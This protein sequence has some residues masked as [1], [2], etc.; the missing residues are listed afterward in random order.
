MPWDEPLLILLFAGIGF[1]TAISAVMVTAW[2]FSGPPVTSARH[3]G[4][5]MIRRYEFRQGYLL[6][7]VDPNDAF[8]TEG[9]DR[10]AAW[11]DLRDSLTALRPDLP[12]AMTALAKRGE[13]FLQTGHLGAD[14]LSVTG[15][16]E[17]DR[18]VIT[19]MPTDDRGSRLPVQ[20]ATLM[21]LQREIVDLRAAVDQTATVMWREGPDMALTWANA[22]YYLLAERI[23]INAAPLGWPLPRVFAD[24]LIPPPAHGALRRCSLTD[25]GATAW[26]DVAAHPQAD[27]TT[28]FA[29]RPVDRLVNAETALRNFVQT[30]SQ[31]FA[32]LPVGLAIFDR[33]RNLVLFNPA[34]VTLSTLE[35]EFLSGR[36][37]LVAFLDQLRERQRMPE[38]KNY[39]TWRDDI[40]RLEQ[41]AEDGTYHELWTLPTGQSYRVIGRPHH[42]GA[43]A[44]MFEDVSSEVSLTRQFRAD[45]DLYQA[46]L[47]DTDDALAVFSGDGR[48]VMSNDGY[49]TLWGTDPRETLGAVSVVE[50]TRQWQAACIPDGVFGD[51][52]SFANRT[53]GRTAWAGALT[54]TSGMRIVARVAP[55]RGGA[56]AVRFRPVEMDIPAQLPALRAPETLRTD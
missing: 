20:R 15:A 45:L 30:L 8:L 21:A 28:L 34:L 54:L 33:S 23:H 31:T 7:D 10:A 39:K 50:A 18:V 19:V 56:M 3:G 49:S 1:L 46:V 17:A 40:A 13:A 47:N 5:D 52:R 41:G 37:S 32:H 25:G 51:I 22:P 4:L 43:V 48:L 42:D 12:D 14:A 29:A 6:N 16:V 2:L 26:F 11:D 27:G 55:L 35:P 24:H 53:R 36:P 38:P 9:V 44:F